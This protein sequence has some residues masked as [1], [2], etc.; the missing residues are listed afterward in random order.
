MLLLDLQLLHKLL[1][2]AKVFAVLLTDLL[3]LGFV[4]LLE[5][6]TELQFGLDEG[7]LLFHGYHLLHLFP[8]LVL[9]LLDLRHNILQLCL[10]YLPT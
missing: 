3:H 10:Q 6:Q 8:S 7:V 2:I 1:V 4:L 9:L 5:L